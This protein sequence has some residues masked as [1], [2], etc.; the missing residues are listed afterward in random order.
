MGASQS[1]EATSLLNKGGRKQVEE[2]SSFERM[3]KQPAFKT[4]VAGSGFLSDSYD[5]FVIDTVNNILRLRYGQTPDEKAGVSNAALVSC[6]S[7]DDLLTRFR[8]TIHDVVCLRAAGRHWERTCFRIR[9]F[10]SKILT[11]RCPTVQIG[12][13]LGQVFFGIAGDA[14]G[15][16]LCFFITSLLIIL[17]ALGSATCYTGGYVSLYLQLCIWRGLLGFGVGG[18]YPLSA[19]LTSE[20]AT[21]A[22]R[23]R[24]VAA[25]FAMQGFG[26][27]LGSV[28]NY[29]VIAYGG[30][31]VSWG[32]PLEWSWR[33]SLAFG[34]VPALLTC[35]FRWRIEESE[36]YS[37]RVAN[38]A[39]EDAE[40]EG[41]SPWIKR[42]IVALRI[43]YEYKWTLVG[44]AGTWF[45]LDVTFYGQGLMNT[46]VVQQ[47]LSLNTSANP[48][49]ALRN[50]ALGALIV[51]AIALPGYILAYFTIDVMGRLKMQL[52]GF[53]ICIGLFCALAWKYTELAAAWGGG[54]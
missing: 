10:A 54:A 20:G 46:T 14:L 7:I 47:A 25:V 32:I 30:E 35:Y 39:A 42:A 12:S 18:E 33:F 38:D 37:R 51:V 43:L 17:G 41:S 16:R 4:F 11:S 27:L 24:S 44:T 9:S 34:A 21:H 28:V 8:S 48:V 31:Y 49:D 15:R 45:L 52:M 1:S 50:G 5:L 23:G 13:V 26:K 6:R 53:T 22:S 3:L 29:L 36:I 19:T 2:L 40:N